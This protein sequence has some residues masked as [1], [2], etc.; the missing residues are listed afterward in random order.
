M[1]E[2][3][4][5]EERQALAADIRALRMERDDM[6]ALKLWMKNAKRTGMNFAYFVGIDPRKAIDEE[7]ARI[8]DNEGKVIKNVRWSSRGGSKMEGAQA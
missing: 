6:G 4:S 7:A 1:S 3:N 8:A 5:V 2:L